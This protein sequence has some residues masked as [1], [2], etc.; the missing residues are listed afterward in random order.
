MILPVVKPI[1]RIAAI[2]ASLIL[3]AL[4]IFAAYGGRFNT[5]IF[6]FPAVLVLVLPYLAITTAIVTV[7]WALCKRI[8]P[9]A[10]GVLAILCAWGPI[11]SVCPLS[12]SKKPTP[13]A[14]TFTLMT[15][16]IVHSRDQRQPEGRQ[17]G[18]P[19]FQYIINSG[20][21]IVC[22]QEL[23]KVD[24]SEIP[25]YETSV[26]DSLKAAYPYQAGD[27]NLDMKVFSKYPVAFEKGYN[28]IT[29]NFDQKRY[30]FYK[31]TIGNRKL[32]VI[33]VHLMSYLLSEEERDVVTGMS[34]VAGMKESVKEMKGSIRAKLANGFSKRK[35]DVDILRE[36][37]K[38]IKGPLI[39]C[40]DF[41]DVPE[42]YAYRVLKGED[43]KDAYVET[44]FGPLVTFNR[45]MFWFHLDQILY[46]GDIRALSVKK[47]SL[48]SSDHYPLTAEFEFT[49]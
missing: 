30:T 49:D 22:V 2:V 37:I 24:G 5:E 25:N 36:S 18:N 47:G 28:Y 6:T 16:N 35:W 11:S 41:N 17:K 8:F 40:G 46:R 39:I 21:D 27:P 7:A 1:L 4:T 26:K 14:K 13:G 44:G 32:T 38:R 29:G 45:H 12:G 31:V 20:A 3:Y 19:T 48:K 23:I 33:N 42:S 9:A 34:S 15:Y 10:L 43:L